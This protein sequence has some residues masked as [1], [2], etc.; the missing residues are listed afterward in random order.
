MWL[1]P[2]AAAVLKGAEQRGAKRLEIADFGSATGMGVTGSIGVVV[3]RSASDEPEHL[4]RDAVGIE[5]LFACTLQLA[6]IAHRLHAARQFGARVRPGRH[7]TLHARE[8]EDA[9]KVQ[10]IGSRFAHGLIDLGYAATHVMRSVADG[11]L[12]PGATSVKAGKL[13]D[14]QVI[15][16]S[17]ILL[18][19]PFVFTKE[20]IGDFDF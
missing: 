2:I 3:G 8:A 6:E 7:H 17:E 20:N 18:G 11:T 13:G 10:T 1:H 9:G 15:N 5:R 16:G 14:L 4:L 19:S 12:K